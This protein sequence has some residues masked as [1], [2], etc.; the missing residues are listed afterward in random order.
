MT[1][2]RFLKEAEDEFKSAILFYA[3]NHDGLGGTFAQELQVCLDRIRDM[4]L[5]S[6]IE[7]GDIRV[8]S[9]ARFPYRVY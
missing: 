8:R 3:K 7:R 5:A 4:P 9:V 1:L 2:M 6:R